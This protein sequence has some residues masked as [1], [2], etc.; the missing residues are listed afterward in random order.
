M[1]VEVIIMRQWG[2]SLWH[3]EDGQEMAEYALLLAVI[4][5]AAAGLLLGPKTSV[6]II[7]NISNSTLANAATLVSH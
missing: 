1:A 6:L 4:S 2:C 5:L 3:D 7:W